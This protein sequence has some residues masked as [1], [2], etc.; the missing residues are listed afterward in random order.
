M[1]G[2]TH[3]DI[4]Q[5]FSHVSTYLK[6]NSVYT[7]GGMYLLIACDTDKNNSC[8]TFLNSILNID[9]EQAVYNSDQEIV[10][11]KQLRRV[12]DY[13]SWLLPYTE[14]PHNHTAPHNFHFCMGSGGK[15]VMFY[16]N[17]S[18]NDWLPAPP[19]DGLTILKIIT[20]I[21]LILVYTKN[22]IQ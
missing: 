18:S 7:L 8:V 19:K 11:V 2:H 12:F 16:C 20:V 22:L 4:D 1:V 6:K 13:K 15:V 17:W 5:M 10:G 3:E 21:M 9:L 14:T